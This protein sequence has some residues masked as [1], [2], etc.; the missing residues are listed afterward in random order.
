[1]ST[2]VES[3][4]SNM[5]VHLCKA[6]LEY[7]L[8]GDKFINRSPLGI[9]GEWVS[10][11]RVDVYHPTKVYQFKHNVI[12]LGSDVTRPISQIETDYGDAT[13]LFKD[14]TIPTADTLPEN[15]PKYTLRCGRREILVPIFIPTDH[16]HISVEFK[17]RV[18]LHDGKVCVYYPSGKSEYLFAKFNEIDRPK[19]IAGLIHKNKASYFT[20]E[21]EGIVINTF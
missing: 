5:H 17:D 16:I 2:A 7:L 11:I 1:M 6:D 10:D 21:N 15:A 13:Y 8:N 20:T 19:T 4:M 18:A 12:V 14:R 3:Q 9:L